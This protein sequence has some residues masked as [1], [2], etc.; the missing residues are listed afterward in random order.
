MKDISSGLKLVKKQ[1]GE[2]VFLSGQLG[3]T[4]F[5]IVKGVVTVKVPYALNN[6]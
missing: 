2:N 5:Y 6:K 3:E 4:L 1:K